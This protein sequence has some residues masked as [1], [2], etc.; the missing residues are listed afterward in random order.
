MTEEEHNDE[1]YKKVIADEEL[2]AFEDILKDGEEILTSTNDY[3]DFVE[4]D[5]R[6]K[7]LK[8]LGIVLGSIVV[9]GA[10]IFG[11]Y[12][13]MSENEATYENTSPEPSVSVTETPTDSPSDDSDNSDAPINPKTPL[14]SLIPEVSDVKTSEVKIE[15]GETSFITTSGITASFSDAKITGADANCTVTNAPDFCY[16]GNVKIEDNKAQVYYL[17]DAAHS[18]FFENPENFKKVEVQGAEASAT[19]NVSISS[20]EKQT[21]LVVVFEDMSGIML[22]FDDNSSINTFVSSITVG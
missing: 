13:L 1:P 6:K 4:K 18:R 7:V 19:M 21:I 9:V 22:T 15:A 20:D 16:A 8:A 5:R 11:V 12:L 10:L 3:T 2:P 17:K 14:L